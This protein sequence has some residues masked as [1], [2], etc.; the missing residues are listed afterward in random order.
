MI[1]MTL[2][3]IAFFSVSCSL[4]KPVNDWQF[5]SS[6]YFKEYMYDFLKD[7]M[8]LAHY[9]LQRAIS[10]TKEGGDLSSLAKI[11]L[12][13][14]ALNISVGL[15]N[16]CEKYQKISPLLE[17]S[18]LDVYYNFIMG[19]LKKEEISQLPKQ[20]HSYAYALIAKD[21]QEAQE[22]L[23]VMPRVSSTLLAA[24]LMREHLTKSS[25]EK[26]IEL[27]SLYG[28]KK[29]IIFWLQESKKDKSSTLEM[30]KI[31]KKIA[32]LKSK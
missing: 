24:A 6:N 20:Y 10:Y 7:D 23:F 27:S 32:I 3:F 22:A 26:L 1:K 14:C 16:K 2:V 28:Y 21:Y 25:R 4:S 19:S 5:K 9:D 8:I 31:D 15:E 30:E 29:S 18:D 17:S 13:E 12:G 11:Y